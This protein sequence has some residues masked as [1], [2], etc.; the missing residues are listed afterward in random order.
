MDWKCDA[1]FAWKYTL[2]IVEWKIF[3]VV[4]TGRHYL[5]YCQHVA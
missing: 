3:E 2:Y 5:N 4:V 1:V